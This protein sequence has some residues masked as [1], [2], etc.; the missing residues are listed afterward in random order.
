LFRHPEGRG[1]DDLEVVI[2]GGSG[3]ERGFV[4]F[5]DPMQWSGG[6]LRFRVESGFLRGGFLGL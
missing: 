4:G 2:D 3:H 1:S 5:G 6:S